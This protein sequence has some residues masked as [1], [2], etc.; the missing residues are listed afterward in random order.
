MAELMKGKVWAERK[1]ATDR[2]GNPIVTYPVGVDL[3]YDEVRCHVSVSGSEVEFIS[4]AG[5][6]LANMKEFSHLFA[7]LCKHTGWNEFDCGFEI[8]QNFNDT[9]RWV[10]STNGLPADLSTSRW[11]FWLFDLPENQSHYKLRRVDMGRVIHYADKYMVG[12][13]AMPEHYECSDEV[14]IDRLFERVVERGIEGLMIKSYDHKYQRGKRIDGWWKYKPSEDADGE[15]TELHEA[16]CGKDQ[17]ELGLRVGDPLGRIGSVTVQL[18]DGS[19]ATPHGIDHTL[20][21]EM[22]LNPQAYLREWCEFTY[23]MRDRQGGYRHPTFKRL[24]EAKK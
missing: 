9:Y 21:R 8:N 17:P 20:G 15:I 6:P 7:H 18:E 24:R 10:R 1:D 19:T 3:K 12:A 2:K 4:Y 23:M 11:R 16:I 22:F 5:K 14:A 13:I